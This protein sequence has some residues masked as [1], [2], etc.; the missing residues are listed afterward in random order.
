MTWNY[1]FSNTSCFV[2]NLIIFFIIVFLNFFKLK[3]K[4]YKSAIAVVI[5]KSKKITLK[6]E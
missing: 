1:M 2:Y 5:K 3:G 4:I 6:A